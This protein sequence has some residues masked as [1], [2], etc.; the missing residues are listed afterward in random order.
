VAEIDIAEDDLRVFLEEAEE[1]LS[2]LDQDITRL[3]KDPHNNELLQEIFRAAHTLKGSSGMLGLK[4]MM[5]L[6]HAME[7]ILD[8]VR[9]G[10]LEVTREL[11]DALLMSIDG[12]KVLKEDIGSPG[13]SVDI[14]PM[15][16]AIHL[17]ARVDGAA[18]DKSESASL[19]SIVSSDVDL[20]GRIHAA[21]AANLNVTR[22]S[23]RVAA[24]ST[25]ASVRL[26]QAIQELGALGDILVTSPSMADIEQEKGGHALE[27]LIAFGEIEGQRRVSDLVD[28]VRRV[29]EIE[30][31]EARPWSEEAQQAVREDDKT[32]AAGPAAAAK[33]TQQTLR[34]D[35][36][37]LDSMMNLVGELIIDRT[38]VNKITKDLRLRYRGDET[39]QALEEIGAHI[40]KMVADL[41]QSMLEARML[42][43][44]V[45]FGKF[46]RLARDVA[47]ATNKEV[48]FVTEG[49]DTEID[50]T[51]IEK[52]KDP[53]MHLLRNAIDHGL[54][55]P[56][57]RER[58]GKSRVGSVRLSACHEQGHI[59]IALED[60]GKGIDADALKQS[61]VEKGVITADAAARMSDAEAID[62]IFQPGFSTARQTSDISGRGVG[63]DVVRNSI[64]SLNG[65]ITVETEVGRGS[66]FKLQ[67]PLTMATFRGLLVQSGDSVYAIPLSYVRETVRLEPGFLETIV[68]REV[69]NLRG[70]VLPLFRLSDFVGR[71]PAAGAPADPRR[72]TEAFIVI[73]RVGERDTAL[74]VDSLV[75]QQEIV[76]KS[77]GAHVGRAKGIAGASILGDGQVALI[78]DVASLSKAA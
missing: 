70:N 4:D 8:K 26:F 59:V 47:R 38:R 40:G 44:G 61:A 57:V 12:L 3:E 7:D 43:V 58:A 11:I 45:I 15:V 21:E 35:V 55:P 13:P 74:A 50:R 60:D 53:L 73:V 34:I 66:I 49:E 2:V 6:T 48:D 19:E 67:L 10:Q 28:A 56:D 32:A 41:N 71:R 1:Q 39:V 30:H 16:E 64:Q 29:D 5:E 36:E 33:D 72:R 75:D 18:A 76:V 78:L 37:R 46:P 25:W 14:G 20:V 63:M 22:V 65:M 24:D 69:V 42:P 51:I 23:V 31:A 17:A 77:M 52:I 54:E 68:D 27:V 62:L 9:K